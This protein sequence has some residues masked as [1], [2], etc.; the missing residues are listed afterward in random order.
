MF[1]INKCPKD[2][3]GN[4]LAQTFEGNPVTLIFTNGREPWLL[5]GYE[6]NTAVSVS[7][8]HKDGSFLP[9]YDPCIHDL[10][11]I[12]EPKR[13]GE[14]WV[15]I[16]AI[17][18]AMHFNGYTTEEQADYNALPKRIACVRVPWTEGEGLEGK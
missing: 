15:N 16:Y 17:E 7:L 8:W 13:S 10:I 12:P 1:D 11:N 18:S 5:G 14:V 6:G 3:D 2:K 4:L 9:S